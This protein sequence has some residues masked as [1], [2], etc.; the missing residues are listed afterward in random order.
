MNGW[1]QQSQILALLTKRLRFAS[2]SCNLISETGRYCTL[3]VVKESGTHPVASHCAF[4]SLLDRKPALLKLSTQI[5]EIFALKIRH[6]LPCP[7]M[8]RTAPL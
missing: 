2:W 5:V 4:S 1:I 7:M 3:R 6:H 8:T